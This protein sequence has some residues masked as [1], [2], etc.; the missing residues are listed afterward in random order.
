[1]D[2]VAVTGGSGFIGTHLVEHL[3]E[4]RYQVLNIDIQTTDLF[5]GRDHYEFKQLDIVDFDNLEKVLNEFLPNYIVHLAAETEALP[6]YTLDD[7][8]TNI[9]GSKNVFELAAKLP[10]LKLLIHTSTQFV[11]QTDFPI[12]E[13]KDYK[14]H[15]VYGE[16]KVIS[17]KSLFE[18]G[19][20]FDY[21][22]IRP[23]NIWGPR[24][25][26]Y[27]KEFWRVLKEG[28]YVHPNKRDVI[29]SYGYVKNIVYQT[30]RIIELHKSKEIELK[31]IYYVGDEPISL[32]EWVDAFSIA[33]L[34]KQSKKVPI[35][36]V[37]IL[38]VVG[39]IFRIIGIKFP[40]TSSR[41]KSMTTSNPADMSDTFKDL[42]EGEY[43][44]QKGVDETTA[45]LK[46][47]YSA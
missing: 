9:I 24:H 25:K 31:E 35:F 1:M 22:I 32:V 15:D 47:Y 45:W 13:L 42:G 16:S 14:P 41:F 44:L 3:L 20:S 28:K 12:K 11:N 10:D 40:I 7:Y 23:T 18:I 38:A 30:F 34:G 27:P 2:K 6:E 26:R 29:R 17:E 37:R 39:D 36:I 5:D 8:P 21:V 19:E 33:L 4:N 46:D 43:D